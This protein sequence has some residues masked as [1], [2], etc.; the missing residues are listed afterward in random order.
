MEQWKHLS[1]VTS[2]MKLIRGYK[3]DR[4]TIRPFLSMVSIEILDERMEGPLSHR[5]VATHS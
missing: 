2:N 1:G 4:V 5:V 3:Q